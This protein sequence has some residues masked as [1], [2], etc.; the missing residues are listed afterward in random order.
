M[1]M[2]LNTL[3]FIYLINYNILFCRHFFLNLFLNLFLNPCDG[4]N[5]RVMVWLYAGGQ[6]FIYYLYCYSQTCPNWQIINFLKRLLPCAT[7]VFFCY[8]LLFSKRF[9]FL[10]FFCL[11]YQD[12]VDLTEVLVLYLFWLNNPII[13]YSRQWREV[14]F[15]FL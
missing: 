2:V 1:R 15:V 5:T 11:S 12:Q 6:K 13:N 14:I 9:S 7:F 10:Q 3:L 8:A 4:Q